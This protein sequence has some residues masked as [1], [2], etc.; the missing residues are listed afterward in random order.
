MNL[1]QFNEYCFFIKKLFFLI[2]K[3]EFSAFEGED[4]G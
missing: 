2:S 1:I 4:F 3:S